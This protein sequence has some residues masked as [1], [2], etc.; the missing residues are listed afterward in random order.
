MDREI[1]TETASGNDPNQRFDGPAP[2]IASTAVLVIWLVSCL[3]FAC[4]LWVQHRKHAEQTIQSVQAI[5][6]YSNHVAILEDKFAQQVLVNATLETNLAAT[7]LKASNDLAAIEAAL[8]T[9]SSSLQKSQAD[10]RAAEEAIAEK[11]KQIAQLADQNTELDQESGDLRGSI[12]NLVAQIA[13]TQMKLD[14]AEGDKALLLEE[15]ARLQAQKDELEKKLS[16]LAFL[17]ETVRKLRADLAIS[18]RLDWIRR[19]IYDA[20]SEKGG[21]R[22]MHPLLAGPAATNSTLDAI[23][24]QNGEVTLNPPVSTNTPYTK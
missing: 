15:L 24:Q 5:T 10:V 3:G 22:L 19:G 11:D 18:R 4:V 23:I 2:I 17:K 14:S 21:E 12:T 8:S 20:L 9:T 1:K 7:Q 16:D 13:A 6:S